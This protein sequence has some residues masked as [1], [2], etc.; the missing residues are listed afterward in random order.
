M[1]ALLVEKQIFIARTYNFLFS[2]LVPPNAI[3]HLAESTLGCVVDEANRSSI[4]GDG[5]TREIGGAAA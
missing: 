4:G 3:G 5:Y 2:L 1:I